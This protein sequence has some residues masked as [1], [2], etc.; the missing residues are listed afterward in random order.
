MVQ[1]KA[2]KARRRAPAKPQKAEPITTL[3]ATDTARRK[4]FQA[5]GHVT[6]SQKA[7]QTGSG[8]TCGYCNVAAA[9]MQGF[10]SD[11][12]LAEGKWTYEHLNQFLWKPKV[13]AGTKMNYIGMKNPNR[14]AIIAWLEHYRIVRRHCHHLNRPANNP[15]KR[16]I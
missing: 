12:M 6:I 11:A 3:A 7:D 16:V 13:I 9:N 5:C 14:A 2:R 8:R 1:S 15:R 10:Y 4:L